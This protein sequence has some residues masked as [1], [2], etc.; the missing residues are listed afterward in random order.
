MVEWSKEVIDGLGIA[1]NEATLLGVEV[2][3]AARKVEVT[4]KVLTLPDVGPAPDDSRILLALS[5]VGRIVAS[6]RHGLWNDETAEVERFTLDSLS[7]VVRSFQ[8]CDIYG[9]EFFDCS[10]ER[11]D[12]CS[13]RLSLDWQSG[14]DGRAH[15][16]DLFQEGNDKGQ[17]RHLDLRISFDDMTLYTPIRAVVP[18]EEFIAGGR[19]WWD[20]L[21]SGDARTQRS[22]IMPLSNV[23]QTDNKP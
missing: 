15:T 18:I 3:E 8:G 4:L 9:W 6:L 11:F 22:G 17:R 20:A 7:D 1:I 16:L 19:R 13:G 2:D 12:R 5:P 14:T 21:Y 23:T 10:D